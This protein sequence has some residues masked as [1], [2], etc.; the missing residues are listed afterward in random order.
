MKSHKPLKW[1]GVILGV[2]I[3]GLASAQLVRPELP[4]FPTDPS[5]TIQ[6]NLASSEV[7]ALVD[8]ACGECH[9]NT[10]SS[11]WYTKVAPFSLLIARGAREGRKVVNFAEWTAYSP[12]QQRAFLLAS[13]SDAT[14]GRMP[15]PAYLRFRPDAK[16]SSRDIETICG[17]SR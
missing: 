7:G 16:L 12:E 13:C 3:A 8:R 10:M 5:H 2:L 9:S 1:A 4:N 6:A 15:V 17:A 14:A 11:R